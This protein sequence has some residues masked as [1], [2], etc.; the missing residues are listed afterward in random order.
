PVGARPRNPWS[1]RVVWITA[2]AGA[3]IAVAIGVAIG[4]RYASN[5]AAPA[6]TV[7]FDVQPPA[8]VT[9]TPSPVAS[10]AQLALSPDGR[11]LAF[12]AARK[13]AASRLWIRPLDGVQAQPLPGTEGAS[14]PFWS[15]D[16]RFLAFFAGGKL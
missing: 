12:V 5:L 2:A 15:P 11:R 13:R 7:R 1:E 16:S 4:E 14:Y 8:D 6:A 9:L 10:A 3:L